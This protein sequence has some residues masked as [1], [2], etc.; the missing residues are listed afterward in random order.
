M[1]F[2]AEDDIAQTVKVSFGNL[3][4]ARFVERCPAPEPMLPPRLVAEAPKKGARGSAVS[5]LYLHY[6]CWSTIN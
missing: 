4:R 1:D 5:D 6:A 2:A 3:A